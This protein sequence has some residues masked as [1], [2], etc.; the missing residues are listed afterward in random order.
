MK[1]LIVISS[2]CLALFGVTSCSSSSGSEEEANSL[3]LK[4][5]ESWDSF[6]TS[7]VYLDFIL[8]G[9]A[10]EASD[11]GLVGSAVWLSARAADSASNQDVKD[12]YEAFSIILG[13]YQYLATSGSNP[14]MQSQ[15]ADTISGV[16]TSYRN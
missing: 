3:A 16:C 11:V 6:V 1:K 15:L 13:Q 14:G 5:C 2:I 4:A 10:F 7:P 9:A 12:E 8:N